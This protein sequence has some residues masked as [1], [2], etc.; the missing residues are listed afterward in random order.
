MKLVLIRDFFFFM[1]KNSTGMSA[2]PIYLY[3]PI[4]F[5]GSESHMVF[6]NTLEIAICEIP[7]AIL[8]FNRQQNKNYR[9]LHRND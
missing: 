4:L 2:P 3:S 7:I 5:S 1:S 9:K 8:F 6:F